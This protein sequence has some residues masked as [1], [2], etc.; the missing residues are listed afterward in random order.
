[1]SIFR[2]NCGLSYRVGIKILFSS[3]CVIVYV[4]RRSFLKG[5]GNGL[6]VI[7]LKLQIDKGGTVVIRICRAYVMKIWMLPSS[8]CL[9]S[10]IAFYCYCYNMQ[11]FDYFKQLLH[12]MKTTGYCTFTNCFKYLFQNFAQRLFT[13]QTLKTSNKN[14][15]ITI[16][17]KPISYIFICYVTKLVLTLKTKHLKENTKKKKCGTY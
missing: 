9:L 13:S 10:C 3:Y 7:C 17:Q 8:F 15:R 2:D 5:K 1:M 12:S 4:M 14:Q 16:K 11:I 6:S